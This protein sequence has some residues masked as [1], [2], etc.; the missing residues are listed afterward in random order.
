MFHFTQ[1]VKVP[2]IADNVASFF[3]KLVISSMETR[4]QK[5][6]IRPDMIHLLME[7]K[8]GKLD[9]KDKDHSKDTGFSTAEE[10]FLGEASVRS[11]NLIHF[12]EVL[13]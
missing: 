12:I 2:V 6:I 9:H 7:A 13:N 5:N 8:K 11:K 4:K 10:S 3:K 1:L